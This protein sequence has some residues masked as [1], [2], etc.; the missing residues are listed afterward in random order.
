MYKRTELGNNQ[1]E[2]REHFKSPMVYLD[3]WALNDL[4]L[5][6]TLSKRFIKIMNEK[7][8][9]FRLS[10][11]NIS[12]L[13][14]MADK[15]Q[16]ESILKMIDSIDDCGLINIDPGEVIRKENA[17]VSDPSLIYVVKKPLC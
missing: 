11:V 15:S 13:S 7:G 2:I 10:V 3:H 8:G 1:I 5:N 12:E 4:S 17:L 14:R 6:G 16:V 9:T